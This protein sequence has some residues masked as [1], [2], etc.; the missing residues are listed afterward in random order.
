[1]NHLHISRSGPT[2]PTGSSGKQ[3]FFTDARRVS[4]SKHSVV[5]YT[6]RWTN[7]ITGVSPALISN[8]AELYQPAEKPNIASGQ[9]KSLT[10]SLLEAKENPSNLPQVQSG[11][12]SPRGVR[13]S[14]EIH[15]G[16]GGIS[17]GMKQMV[18]NE[19]ESEL[20][21]ATHIRAPNYSRVEAHLYE[22]PL[23]STGR[24]RGE[25]DSLTANHI[26][27]RLASERGH[28]NPVGLFGMD[29]L[30]LAHPATA[31]PAYR[32]DKYSS[33]SVRHIDRPETAEPPPAVD[34]EPCERCKPENER[35]IESLRSLV[36]KVGHT[37]PDVRILQEI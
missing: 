1:M 20:A 10:A 22:G 32:L 18:D 7:T 24:N 29:D 11:H 33:E 4:Q 9:S 15:V 3:P 16:V 23:L 13:D 2:S 35:T 8:R 5:G 19:E 37:N 25:R 6:D 12:H 17:Y 34:D 36:F 14:R 26:S 30:H 31:R 27:D 28:S 21:K